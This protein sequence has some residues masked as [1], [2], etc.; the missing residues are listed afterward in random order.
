MSPDKPISSQQ[1]NKAPRSIKKTKI[2][3]TVGPASSSREMLSE[4]IIAGVNIFRLNFAHGAYD[5]LEAIVENIRTLS[6]ELDKPVGILGDL[7]GPKIRLGELPEDGV[8]CLM[9]ETFEFYRD[10]DPKDPLKLTCTYESLIDDLNVGD[11]VLLADGIVAMRVVEKS[12]SEGRVVCV[13]ERPGIIRSK[14]GI[15]LPGVKLRTPSLTE[16]DEQD[17]NWALDNE[18]DFIGLSFVR[19][20]EDI[21]H[22]R[23]KIQL[24]KSMHKPTIVAKIEKVEAVDDLINILEATDAVMVAR[25]DLGVEADIIRVPIL[26]KHII[27][28]CNKYRI[29]VITATQMLDSMHH[30]P[31][32]TRAEATDVANAV[33]D[34]T[35]A[36]MLSGETAVGSY[37]VETVKM[38]SRIV[39]E[40][41][42]L[43]TPRD[44]SGD[45]KSFT[46]N[47]ALHVTEVITRAAGLAARH[48]D[49]D[50]MVLCTQSGR[51][52]LSISEQRLPIPLLALTDDINTSRKM[53]LF[54]GVIPLICNVVQ[55]DDPRSVL[56][57][58]TSWGK[59]LGVLKS[60]SKIVLIL[61]TEWAADGHDLLMVHV[62]P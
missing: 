20:A 57:H 28:S 3:A 27:E 38:M 31:F 55:E 34:G 48:L 53:T 13:V 14:Q 42:S 18:I 5:W 17:L 58:V 43:I 29:P 44:L 10:A 1:T 47:R 37:P 23:G 35:D 19:E 41:S 56:N 11:P 4:L 24:H 46:K 25:G 2:V 50:L 8:N 61:D 60:G 9:G 30:N 26:Q 33:I 62:M 21:R 59:E 16:K 32:P 52:A 51:T 15:N 6:I 7:S 40:A 22:L 12:E 49:A 39:Q 45:S 54:W 36:V